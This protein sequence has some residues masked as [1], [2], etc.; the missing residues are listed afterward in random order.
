MFVLLRANVVTGCTHHITSAH[1]K[2]RREKHTEEH[3]LLHHWIWT[4]FYLNVVLPVACAKVWELC[5]KAKFSIMEKML[6]VF[7]KQDSVKHYLFWQMQSIL[8]VQVMFSLPFFFFLRKKKMLA[9]VC[10]QK[11]PNKRT[12]EM[13]GKY[14]W[15]RKW[16]STTRRAGSVVKCS[17]RQRAW[18]WPILRV[19]RGLSSPKGFQRAVRE[20]NNRLHYLISTGQGYRNSLAAVRAVMP[21]PKLSEV[22]IYS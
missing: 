9:L 22:I 2:P 20:R 18:R 13:E 21:S 19:V 5:V 4:A 14:D 12:E 1:G 7:G 3:S 6:L 17:C 15:F 16:L 10:T 11:E 8:V